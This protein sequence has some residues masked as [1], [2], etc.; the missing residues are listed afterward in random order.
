MADQLAQRGAEAAAAPIRSAIKALNVADARA[1]LAHQ[2]IGAI[3]A[4]CC[5]ELDRGDRGEFGGSL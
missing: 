1:T 3:L 5:S 4:H 2:R